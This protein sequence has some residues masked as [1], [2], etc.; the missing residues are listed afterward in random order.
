MTEISYETARR[1][2]PVDALEFSTTKELKSLSGFIGQEKGIDAI[3]FGIELRGYGYNVFISGP[4][5][6][7]K[8][9]AIIDYLKEQADKLPTPPDWC[10]VYNFAD[11]QRPK[12]LKLLAGK[13]RELQ[14][15]MEWFI[16]KTRDALVNAFSSDEYHQLKNKTLESIEIE[17]RNIVERMKVKAAEVGFDLERSPVG[18]TLTPILEGRKIGEEEFSN[19]PVEIQSSI[20]EKRKELQD[21][22][23]SLIRLFAEL[24]KNADT[25]IEELNRNISSYSIDPLLQMMHDLYDDTAS[26]KEYLDEVREDILSNLDLIM[27]MGGAQE[28][29]QDAMK[30]Y[31]VNLLIDNSGRKGSR[32]VTVP[33]ATYRHIFGYLEKEVKAGVIST[34]FTLIRPG[35]AHNAIGGFLVLTAADLFIN[36]YVWYSLKRALRDVSLEIE[37]TPEPREYLATNVIMPEAIPFD[38]KVILLGDSMQ[39]YS[40]YHQDADF[41]ELFKVK[42]DFDTSM[43][44]NEENVTLYC[45]FISKICEKE[46]LKP[47]DPSAV[48]AIIEYC[49]RLASDQKKLSTRFGE[50]ADLLIE[51]DYYSLKDGVTTSSSRH[52]SQALEQRVYRSNLIQQK[53]E[54]MIARG[55]LLVDTEGEKIG[56]VNGLAVISMGNYSFGRPSRVTVSTGVGKG[57]V[58]DI[59]REA[60]LGGPIHTKGVQILSGYLNEMYAQ[61]V[62]LSLTARLVFEQSYSGIEGD[63]ASSTELYTLLSALSGKPINQNL[64]VTGSVNQR[65]EVQA[66][67]GVNEKIEGYYEVCKAKG[68]NGEQGVLIPASN[69][70][71]LM[72]KE[73]VVESMRQGKFHVFSVRTIGEGIEVLT[74]VKAGERQVNGMYEEETINRLVQDRLVEMADRVKEYTK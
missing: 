61:E 45:G 21:G 67:G 31:Q 63:S 12:T 59:E 25:A 36:P 40:L 74:G 23:R 14:K 3:L 37:D 13:G 2:L 17:R 30:K 4:S 10:Y 6:T 42:A 22:L 38:A 33:H 60:E 62:P 18:L 50:V 39:Y 27:E 44:W 52:V 55:V 48:A 11:S 28:G 16:D 9:S 53:I 54:E 46:G 1:R 51:V 34:D 66:I 15:N 71:N 65:G 57:G 58:I 72:L 35:A 68:L 32:V 8:K 64:A 19:L 73:D 7:G 26:V 56:Q 49:S 20:V 69:V 41:K 43:D 29:L 70:E 47:L 24:E 5:G